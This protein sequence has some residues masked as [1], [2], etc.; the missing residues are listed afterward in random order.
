MLTNVALDRMSP[1]VRLTSLMAIYLLLASAYAA[2]L[3][4]SVCALH[5]P[6]L[7]AALHVSAGS[8]AAVHARRSSATQ[9]ASGPSLVAFSLVYGLLVGMR[10]A[11]NGVMHATLFG[12][13][14]I[15]RIQG[16]AIGVGIAAGGCGPL[17]FTLINEHSGSYTAGIVGCSLAQVVFAL[18][19]FVYLVVRALSSEFET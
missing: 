5:A 16:M 13:G 11:F 3:L 19:T 14:A 12:I 1:K 18:A 4:V 2:V 6:P 10:N 7:A 9:V 8:W 17:L 15:D